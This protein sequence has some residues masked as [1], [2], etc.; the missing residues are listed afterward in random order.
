MP[1]Y[2]NKRLDERKGL[3]Y[4]KHYIGDFTQDREDIPKS[5]SGFCLEW[6]RRIKT[7]RFKSG[8]S[9]FL[10]D[11]NAGLKRKSRLQMAIDT[12]GI[13]QTVRGQTWQRILSMEKDAAFLDKVKK[14]YDVDL[15]TSL[16]P[17]W[18]A[19]LIAATN[20]PASYD[21]IYSDVD[22]DFMDVR[23]GIELMKAHHAALATNVHM[24]FKK[25]W[26]EKVLKT[27][28]REVPQQFKNPLTG[29]VHT[30]PLKKTETYQE[31][32]VNNFSGITVKE[33]DFF[34]TD[35]TNREFFTGPLLFQKFLGD[36]IKKLTPNE[37]AMLS[38]KGMSKVGHDIAFFFDGASY[39]F[40]DP[41]FGEF[42]FMPGE[43][44]SDLKSIFVEIFD[45]FY[46][47]QIYMCE[48]IVFV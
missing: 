19:K 22:W 15:S 27:K 17:E 35:I 8:E 30:L 11:S 10:L 40:L 42:V 48:W 41:N 47:K 33:T 3:D 1:L 34:N 16:K 23:K 24:Q 18:K 2:G 38:W 45:N 4:K 25:N 46:Q 29:A 32:P 39:Y 37:A 20:D 26:E 14:K 13:Y 43:I 21:A 44:D 9:V 5:C 7:G 6:I 36:K 28:T 12:H 31:K